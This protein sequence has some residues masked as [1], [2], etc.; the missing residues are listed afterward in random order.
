M[1]KSIQ[2]VHSVNSNVII[3]EKEG[4]VKL[5]RLKNDCEYELLKDYECA[6]GFCKS[7]AFDNNLIVP[8][9]NGTLDLLDIENGFEIIRTFK[10]TIEGNL[11]NVM[12]LQK[13]EIANCIYV[14]AGFEAGDVV[15]WDFET[16][17][18]CSHIK[19]REY[20]T[21]LTFDAVTGRGICGNASNI[22]QIF[23]IDKNFN[24]TLKCELSMTN[25]GCNVVKLR[26]DRKIFVSG[27]WD[28]RLR[29][30]SWKSLRLLAVLTEHQEGVTDVQFS[31]K[32]VKY[33]N[34]NIMAASGAD[35]V[36]S[37][38]NLYN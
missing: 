19:L 24:I 20:I 3:Q 13:V 1:G 35:G 23:T 34:S 14:L 12:C 31:P 9:E 4:A 16:S 32:T 29:L 10:A 7:L 17:K 22:L 8:K 18:Q 27:G 21:S 5:W 11:G 6:G 36:I 25:N 2:A 33:W 37:L 30:F 28:G 15:L 38:W 26:P